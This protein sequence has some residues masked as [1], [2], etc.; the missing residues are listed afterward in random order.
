MVADDYQLRLS[1]GIFYRTY[2]S[3]GCQLLHSGV[4]HR[5]G[6]S[7]G[8]HRLATRCR[9]HRSITQSVKI[10][11]STS[12]VLEGESLLNDASSLI[13][14]RFALVAVGTGQ[15]VLQEAAADFLWMVFGGAG[16]GLFLAWLF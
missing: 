9:T 6:L 12:A 11:R 7:V 16:M 14:F 13:I 5:I 4:Y 2:R 8:R 3:I 10:P 1:G 15:F